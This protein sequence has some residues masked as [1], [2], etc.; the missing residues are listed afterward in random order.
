ML[1]SSRHRRERGHSCV[2]PHCPCTELIVPA[3]ALQHQALHQWPQRYD[4]KHIWYPAKPK[5]HYFCVRLTQLPLPTT[6]IQPSTH[7]HLPY[8][9]VVQSEQALNGHSPPSAGERSQWVRVTVNVQ[10]SQVTAKECPAQNKE[11]ATAASS[12]PRQQ[13]CVPLPFHHTAD[14]RLPRMYDGGAVR[15]TS[16]SGQPWVLH[17]V[18]DDR[19]EAPYMVCLHRVLL[20]VVVHRQQ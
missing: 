16:L 12:G 5:P 11:L 13:L 3:Q 14:L 10:H 1:W 9:S 7:T 2:Q 6:P 18:G 17:V 19:M 20:C 15:H 8:P 4:L